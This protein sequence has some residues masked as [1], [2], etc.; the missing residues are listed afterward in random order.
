MPTTI[1]NTPSA[2]G[3]SAACPKLPFPSFAFSLLR[4]EGS[5]PVHVPPALVTN[6]RGI[7]CLPKPISRRFLPAKEWRCA[8]WAATTHFRTGLPKV[9]E[10]CNLA[11]ENFGQFLQRTERVPSSSTQYRPPQSLAQRAL[12]RRIVY[13]RLR[14]LSSGVCIVRVMFRSGRSGLYFGWPQCPAEGE[15]I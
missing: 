15:L 10:H 11:A 4:T 6:R 13:Q 14:R 1:S 9:T 2:K 7:E 3:I 12:S 8:S 5:M